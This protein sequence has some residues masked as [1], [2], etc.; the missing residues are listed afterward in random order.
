MKGRLKI[1]AVIGLVLLF[2]VV[3]LYSAIA[4]TAPTTPQSGGILKRMYYSDTGTPLGWPIED[5]PWGRFFGSPCLEML[6][7]VG[8]SGEIMPVLATDWKVA[9]DKKSI[10][11]TLRKGVKF[12]DG[13]DWNAEA[14]K[15]TLDAFLAGK[16]PE[17]AGTTSVDVIDNYTIR[18]NLS[19][20]KNTIL[21]NLVPFVSPTAFKKNGIEWARQNPVGTGPFKF[22][23]RSRDVSTKFEKFN[24]YWQK[25]KPYLD[26]VEFVFIKD[27]MTAQFAF[28]AGEVHTVEMVGKQG[29]EL[30][31]KGYQFACPPLEWS[32]AFIPDSGRPGSP[33][34]DKRVRQA[35]EYAIDRE[36]I[37]KAVGFGFLK[38]AYQLFP[39]HPLGNIPDLEGRRY[40]PAKAKQLLADAGYP[41]G[42]KT[43]IIPEPA[44]LNKDALVAVQRY[45]GEVGIQVDLDIVET[46]RYIEYRYKGWDGL[47]NQGIPN[48]GNYMRN[49]ESYFAGDQYPSMKF[50]EG[51]MDLYMQAL[52]TA[53]VEAE[54]VRKLQKLMFDEATVMP[55]LTRTPTTFIR[56]GVHD[57]GVYSKGIGPY[58]T[59]ENAWL[60]KKEQRK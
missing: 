44:T 9:S 57:A 8:L 12:H 56:G 33:F 16:K 40:S 13:T 10:T 55:Y 17:V 37:A 14:A 11:F 43:R 2:V 3:C 30:R 47:L 46:G 58:F 18:M 4:A 31:D 60:E 29:A 22:V 45:L 54:K 26:G 5:D 49:Y 38:A 53:N 6:V 51:Y 39:G 25:G 24:N 19:I 52:S 34:A 32:Y 1:I 28:E 36:A 21:G 50:P 48:Y 23:S 15:F 35:V 41:N 42:F 59:P 27:P 20:F 7:E